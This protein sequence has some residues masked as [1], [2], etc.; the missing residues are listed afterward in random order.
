MAETGM[1]MDFVQICPGEQTLFSLCFS[2]PD[3]SGGNLTTD[4][5]AC[6]RLSAADV[7]HAQPVFLQYT[8]R[9]VALAAPEV[10]LAARGK[11]LEMGSDCGFFRA[12][13]FTSSEIGDAI[14]TGLLTKLDLLAVNLDEARFAAGIP[15]EELPAER[16]IQILADRVSS[17]NP[18]LSFSVT[19]GKQG[20]W[21]WDGK[22]IYHQ[23][24]YIV[25]VA[26]TAGAGD[27]HLAAVIA[28][29]AAGLTLAESLELGSLVAAHSVTSP[30]TIDK[31]IERHQLRSFA[32]QFHLD[33]S[34]RIH[35]LLAEDSTE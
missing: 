7:E 2:Y 31:R 9:G 25:P 23:P 34:P 32:A 21:C 1:E 6:D 15:D 33:L 20:S 12:A 28:G 30:H 14:Q 3:G 16:V 10:P 8:G 24:A 11:L 18:N 26:G 35:Q 29:R 27:A 13:S 5:S 22:E 4:D 17:I 19:A